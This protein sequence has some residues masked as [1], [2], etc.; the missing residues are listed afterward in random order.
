MSPNPPVSL[1]M[2]EWNRAKLIESVVQTGLKPGRAAERLGMSRRRVA[3]LGHRC[4]ADG[5]KISFRCAVAGQ[6]IIA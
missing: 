2:R 3:R 1:T 6:A 4:P 5:A